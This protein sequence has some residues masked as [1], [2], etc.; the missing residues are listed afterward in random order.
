[1]QR[2]AVRTLVE[3]AAR[4]KAIFFTAQIEGSLSTLHDA[5]DRLTHIGDVY[6]SLPSDL[7]SGLIPG[8]SV[9]TPRD[10]LRIT[11]DD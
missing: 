10:Q 2:A 8:P 7:S 6:G 1:V 4:L 11:V 3:L 5:L 9:I